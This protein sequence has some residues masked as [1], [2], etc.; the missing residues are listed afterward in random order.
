VYAWVRLDSR[1]GW[2]P[3]T[4]PGF[5]IGGSGGAEW[6]PWEA[7]ASVS[8]TTATA[9]LQLEG[10]RRVDEWT[11]A[12]L[13]GWAPAGRVAPTVEVAAGL[14]VR[15]YLQAGEGVAEAAVPT[16]RVTVGLSVELGSALALVPAVSAASDLRATDLSTPEGGTTTLSPWSFAA[17]VSV[18]LA[19]KNP[20]DHAIRSGGARHAEGE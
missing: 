14:D 4:S 19:S 3:S 15:R 2:R 6:G 17:G 7:G 5:E 20:Q 13:G 10:D 11:V 18:R 8:G 9:L 1:A 16:A 12:A